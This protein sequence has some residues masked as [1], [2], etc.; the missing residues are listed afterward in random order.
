MK[1]SKVIFLDHDGVICLPHQHGG[2]FKKMKEFQRINGNTSD[3]N[4]PVHIRFDDFDKKAVSALNNI[5]FE[6]GAD[7]IISSDWRIHATLSELQDFYFA[8]GVM[9]APL[10]F[11]PRLKDF[12]FEKSERLTRNMNLEAIRVEEIRE[13]LRNNIVD[14]WVAVDDLAM[15]DLGHNFVWT[16]KINEGIKQNGIA[17]KII[18]LLNED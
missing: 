7:I 10:G 15:V 14:R 5:L 18:D 4:L 13:W 12:D 2:R 3:S 17:H 9:K 16:P 8:Q 6:T 11:T 1:N